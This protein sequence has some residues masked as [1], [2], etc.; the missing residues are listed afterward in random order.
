MTDEKNFCELDTLLNEAVLWLSACFDG[1]FLT[2]IYETLVLRTNR[3]H[4]REEIINQISENLAIFDDDLWQVEI[5]Q[6]SH[7]DFVLDTGR[8]LSLETTGLSKHRLDG[9]ETPIVVDLLGK[10]RFSEG[11]EGHELL[12]EVLGLLETFSHKHVFAN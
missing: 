12:R 1:N 7:Q 3:V 5:S 9:S 4:V 2:R 11:V 8:I 6:G 10:K